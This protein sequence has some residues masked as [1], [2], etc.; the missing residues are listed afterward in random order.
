MTAKHLDLM[1]AKT[2]KAMM[3]AL[4][5]VVKKLMLKKRFLSLK[6]HRTKNLEDI[7]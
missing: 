2:G 1:D 4:E 3:K 6:L 7:F 5:N